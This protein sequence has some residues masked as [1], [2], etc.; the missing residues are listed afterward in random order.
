[1]GAE[2]L[3]LHK[4]LRSIARQRTQCI[5]FAWMCRYRPGEV[6][7]ESDVQ[8]VSLHLL[9]FHPTHAEKTAAGVKGMK[10]RGG[11]NE[12]EGWKDRWVA[13]RR[14]RRRK[15]DYSDWLLMSGMPDAADDCS[16]CW[17]R[18][19]RRL[20]PYGLLRCKTPV[21]SARSLAAAYLLYFLEEVL[22]YQP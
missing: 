4:P 9:A 11:S 22:T 8:F 12:V 7:S 2:G 16:F 10:V 5:W 1:M 21:L 13:G 20:Q 17:S 15:I 6:L 14:W 19:M 18:C 3:K